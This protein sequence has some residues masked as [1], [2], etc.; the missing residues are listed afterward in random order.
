MNYRIACPEVPQDHVWKKEEVVIGQQ[1]GNQETTSSFDQKQPEP[2]L[3]KEEQQE[4]CQHEGQVIQKQEHASFLVNS[5]EETDSCD[6]EPHRN[7]PL[8]QNSTK[9]ENQDQDGYRNENS[10][11]SSNEELTQNKNV[12]KPKITKTM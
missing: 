5:P 7:Q 3:I 2:P 10:E 4:L 9:S 8:C 12:S 6:P 1:F 11:P